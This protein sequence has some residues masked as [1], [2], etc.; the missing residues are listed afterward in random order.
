MKTVQTITNGLHNLHAKIKDT[1][2]IASN[3]GIHR[4]APTIH[5]KLDQTNKWLINPYFNI[6]NGIGEK[7]GRFIINE[8]RVLAISQCKDVEDR[9]DFLQ[10]AYETELLL[11]QLINK[12]KKENSDP[13][14]HK[15]LSQQKI[16]L[17]AVDLGKQLIEKFKLLSKQIKRCLIQQVAD[18]FIDINHP[19][20]KLAEVGMNRAKN[21]KL[22]PDTMRKKYDTAA[23]D[24]LNHT[25]KL[26]KTAQQ[27]ASVTNQSRNKQTT[28][29]IN[30]LTIRVSGY[31]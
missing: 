13:Y 21:N 14:N 18:D 3:Y 10:K 28:E 20:K 7:A 9:E 5:G 12:L 25:K 31:Y 8:C 4:L 22:D 2:Q 1:T 11:N 17:N 6:N 23:N 16:D 15:S 19:L 24:F 29:L 30:E 26:C 27:L